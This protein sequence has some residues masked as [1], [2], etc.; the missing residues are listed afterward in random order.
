MRWIEGKLK[1]RAWLPF[2]VSVDQKVFGRFGVLPMTNLGPAPVVAPGLVG[3]NQRL[4][5]AP[6]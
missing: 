2:Y 4:G 3:S 1:L 6:E 5:P